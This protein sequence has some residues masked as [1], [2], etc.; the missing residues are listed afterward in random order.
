MAMNLAQINSSIP[1]VVVQAALINQIGKRSSIPLSKI[2]FGIT[3][4]A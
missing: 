2:G 4:T 1:G 3:V